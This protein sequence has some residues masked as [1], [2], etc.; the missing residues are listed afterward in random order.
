MTGSAI[1]LISL[2]GATG[3]LRATLRV[4]VLHGEHLADLQSRRI[5]FLLALWHGRMFLIIDEHRG[6]GIVT[7]ASKSKDGDIISGWL[8]HNGYVV[9]RGS[10]TRGGSEALRRMVYQMRAGRNGALTVDGPK[11]PVRVVQPGVVR[12]ARLTGAWI[13]PVSFSSSWPLFFRSWDRHLVPKPFSRNFLSYGEPFPIGAD[14]S[15]EAA[16]TKIAAAI[17]KITDEVDRMAGICPPG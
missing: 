10:T 9:V 1:L 11:G 5:P 3:L 2:R 13:L 12:L 15:D 4:E 14:L 6:K 8:E 16:L 7:M 17:N